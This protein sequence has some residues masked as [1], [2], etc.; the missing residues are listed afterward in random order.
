[1][2]VLSMVSLVASTSCMSPLPPPPAGD[3]SVQQI[4]LINLLQD[5]KQAPATKPKPSTSI[6]V[7]DN[8]VEILVPKK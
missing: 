3:G 5:N 2:L 6:R 7:T 1:M 8:G 4:G